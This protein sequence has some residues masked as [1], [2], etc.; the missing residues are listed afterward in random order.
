M[1][2]PSTH[3]SS[4]SRSGTTV[5]LPAP[6]GARSTATPAEASAA[7]NAGT[8]S[9]TGRAIDSHHRSTLAGP[10]AT[11]RKPSHVHG[12]PRRSAQRGHRRPRRPRQDDPRRP[13][14]V[15]VGRLPFQPGRRRA[16]HGLHGPRAGEGHHHPRQEHDGPLRRRH[17]QHRRHAR[18]RRLRRRGRAGAV[19]GRRRAAPRRRLRGPAAPDPLRAPQGPL[20]PPA[21]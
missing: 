8:A 10:P 15:A 20:R 12:D 16:G 2:R 7:R 1:R 9:S 11:I 4:R 6:G 21:R 3:G 13:A 19:D 17:R 18:P 5:D 14:A